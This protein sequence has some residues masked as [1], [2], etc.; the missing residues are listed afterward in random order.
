MDDCIF[1]KIVKGELST[2]KIY[3]DEKFLSFLTTG[4]VTAGHL[5]IIP[6][7]H[8]VWFYE[9]SDEKLS[10]IMLMAKKIAKAMKAALGSDF[11]HLAIAGSEVPHL[12]IHLFP[13]W[14]KDGLPEFPHIEYK[15][16]EKKEVAKKIASAL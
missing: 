12:H 4:P 1:C 6:K 3:E 14:H 10:E 2:T 8:V 9:E 5:L 15:E 11:V 16:G 13:R 7:E